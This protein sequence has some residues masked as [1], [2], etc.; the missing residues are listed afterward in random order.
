MFREFLVYHSDSLEFRAKILT[1]AM[2][3]DTLYYPCKIK[4]LEKIAKITYPY[5]YNR[6][7]LLI[8]TV[9]EYIEK[10]KDDNGLDFEHLILLVE[11]EVREA[12]Q[13]TEKI[14][15]TLLELFQVCIEDEENRAYHQ[16]VLHFL[17]QLKIGK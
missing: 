4:T 10:I 15:L 5:D 6:A 3:S 13:F 8:E 1:L 2:A 12:K 16:K 17:E 11:K 7:E 9:I 14:D